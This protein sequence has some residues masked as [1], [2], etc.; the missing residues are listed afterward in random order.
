MNSG[1]LKPTDLNWL[2]MVPLELLAGLFVLTFLLEVL[3]APEGRTVAGFWTLLTGAL[4][5][6][7]LVAFP[8]AGPAAVVHQMWIYDSVTRLGSLIIFLCLTLV[9]LVVP[10]RIQ[11]S[12][13]LGEYYAL[14]AGASLGMV[15]LIGS[16]SLIVS[17][18]ALELFSLALYL[19]C[20]FLPERKEC[21]ESGLKYFILS[22]L[23]SAVMLYG[24]A[25][26]YGACGSTWLT[27]IAVQANKGGLLLMVGSSLLAAGLAFKVSAVPFHLWT[28]DVYEGAPTPVT[29]FMSVATKAA[30][31][32]AMLRF[33]PMTLGMAGGPMDQL[34]IEW[35]TILWSLCILSMIFGNVMALSQTNLKRLLAYSGVAQAGYL[36]SAVF[37]GT[38]AGRVSLFFYLLVYAF[39]NLGAFLVVMALEELGEDLDLSSLSGLS[40]RQPLLAGSLAVCLFS[41][42]GLPPTAGFLAKYQLFVSLLNSPGGLLPRYLVAA[43]LVG[44]L[45]S[46]GYYLKVVA[47]VYR[48]GP[49]AVGQPQLAATHWVVLGL[50]T[51]GVLGLFV[52]AQP[53]LSWMSNL[54]G[55]AQ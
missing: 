32:V 34:R 39:M 20:I 54:L 46:A 30:A 23:A 28:P 10:R 53:V 51:S 2:A 52:A 55:A 16:N 26:I 49:T 1:I 38:A 44:S 6:L 37:V 12:G 25:L 47:S 9:S 50:C 8:D 43:G 19:L 5:C 14:L 11:E 42:T 4:G 35:W 21:Q 18:L 33:F 27:D 24:M 29:A 45:V 13:H 22:S 7:Y 15:L 31:L 3:R 40:M 17:F 36:L 48:P 41:L